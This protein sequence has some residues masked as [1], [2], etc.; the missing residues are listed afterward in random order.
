[1]GANWKVH[2][3]FAFLFLFT[4]LIAAPAQAQGAGIRVLDETF[5]YT[6]G[7]QAVFEIEIEGNL[8]EANLFYTIEGELG[9]NFRRA[10]ISG[11]K[12]TAIVSLTTGEIPPASLVTYFW[13]LEDTRG[14]LLRT[15]EQSFRYLDQRFAWKSKTRDDVTVFW[16][17]RD[18]IGNQA[19]D[20]AK[21]SLVVIE[22]LLGF[23]QI[24]PI[25]IIAYQNWSDMRP[26]VVE[27]WGEHQVVS[28]GVAM[29]A[30]TAVFF[31]HASWERTLTHELAHV[32]TSQLIEGPYDRLPFWLSE[33]LATY[34]EDQTRLGTQNPLSIG[35]LSSG[36]T[37]QEDIG[38]AYAQAQSLVTF[39]VQEQGG[40]KN[41]IELLATMSQG[42]TLD[43]ALTS[44]YSFDRYELER[45]WQAWLGNPI[46]EEPKPQPQ[47]QLD[48][49]RV[50]LAAGVFSA[51]C[52]MLFLILL[53]IFWRRLEE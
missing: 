46:P 25:R 21:K 31:R 49:I 11:G 37:R 13:R 18:S 39:L 4:S 7:K 32:L 47:V 36:P 10:Q 29:N 34:T 22:D 17:G 27:R 35:L 50:A 30:Q 1:M 45:K 16:Y 48:L 28:L 38:P 6:F 42:E 15:R 40:K 14:Q 33:G 43:N 52:L 12:A 51:L 3:T 20:Q 26:A 2:L 41:V 5:S 8:K 23:T 24:Q 44:V 53:R 9:Q 19:L